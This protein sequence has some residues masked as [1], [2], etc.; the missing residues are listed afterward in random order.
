MQIDP[1]HARCAPDRIPEL[2]RRALWR[3]HSNQGHADHA[4]P[5][6]GGQPLDMQQWDGGLLPDGLTYQFVAVDVNFK[7]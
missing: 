6:N 3:E 1:G 5:A 7:A 4:L 2:S